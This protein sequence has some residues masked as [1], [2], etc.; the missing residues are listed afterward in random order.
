MI[1]LS[2]TAAAAAATNTTAVVGGVLCIL[3][4]L[5]LLAGVSTTLLV[6]YRCKNNV[7]DSSPGVSDANATVLPSS[8]APVI[9]SPA[10]GK[11]HTVI[12]DSQDSISECAGSL[13]ANTRSEASENV[14]HLSGDMVPGSDRET[15]AGDQNNPGPEDVSLSILD[16]CHNIQG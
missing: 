7:K 10:N 2:C 11:F 16:V 4:V 9:H 6:I 3:A 12:T 15:S 8:S 5:I 14:Y 1:M 13:P